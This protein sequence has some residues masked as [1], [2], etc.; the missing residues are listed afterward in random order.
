[1]VEE[2]WYNQ[3]MAIDRKKAYHRTYDLL[4]NHFGSRHWWPAKTRFEVILGT[5][6][7]QNTSWHNASRAIANLRG[8]GVLSYR[9]MQ[10]V[11]IARL[12]RLIK[13]ALYFNTKARYLKNILAYMRA[14]GN[15]NLKVFF[16][17]NGEELRRR[18]LTV[19]GVGEETADSIL[20]YAGELPT[21]VVDAYTRRIFSRLGLM[22]ED[23]SYAEMKGEFENHLPRRVKLYNE[24]HALITTFGHRVCKKQPLCDQ[25]PLRRDK[26]LTSMLRRSKGCL[27]N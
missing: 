20:L 23:V 18:L 25:C 14:N 27:A 10:A 12:R 15:G 8:A 9:G 11:P 13:P 19:K 26:R 21:F 7:T 3:Q 4:L 24:Y 17:G 16:R 1:M 2:P 6:L 22:A 5:I